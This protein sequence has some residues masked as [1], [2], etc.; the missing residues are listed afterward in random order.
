M[1]PGTCLRL[2]PPSRSLC[3]RLLLKRAK[4]TLVSLDCLKPKKAPVSASTRRSPDRRLELVCGQSPHLAANQVSGHALVELGLRSAASPR[5][6]LVTAT[7][8]LSSGKGMRAQ[9]SRS[10]G[11]KIASRA[12][13]V[14]PASRP[15]AKPAPLLHVLSERA[16][17]LEPVVR[18]GS[19]PSHAL[20]DPMQLTIARMG[21]SGP[22]LNQERSGV[23]AKGLP[24]SRPLT[25]T[26]VARPA[27]ILAI[28]RGH[29]SATDRLVHSP[30]VRAELIVVSG[31]PVVVSSG[32]G[33]T[34]HGRRLVVAAE[35]GGPAEAASQHVSR[36]RHAR[37]VSGLRPAATEVSRRAGNAKFSG[38]STLHAVPSP[39]APSQSSAQNQVLE[40]SRA[41]AAIALPVQLLEET[42]PRVLPLGQIAASGRPGPPRHGKAGRIVRGPRSEASQ[43]LG[44]RS[45]SA[46]AESR[47]HLPGKVARSPSLQ[48]EP[49][50]SASL[51]RV[52]LAGPEA[53]LPATTSRADS[54]PL[55][56]GINSRRDQ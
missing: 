27:V 17:P 12:R 24:E 9:A 31:P 41:L 53:S 54:L 25:E 52:N 44:R 11:R 19:L 35:K 29:P 23:N 8:A 42:A 16:L 14:R 2:P 55:A 15:E 30:R 28:R 20:I 1:S 36:L 13:K 7:G 4:Q 32:R 39:S 46:L 40:R 37:A 5:L 26:R 38:N 43:A 33:P 6:A 48:T 56:A 34:P 47:L 18:V 45:R 3:K 10:R 51:V 49:N 22:S 21:R 50:P